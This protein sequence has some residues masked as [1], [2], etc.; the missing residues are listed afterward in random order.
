MSTL[1]RTE[2][3]LRP[4]EWHFG[5]RE[6]LIRTLLGSCVSITL[7]HPKYKLGGMCH[8]MLARRGKPHGN[9]L[10]GR[11]ADEAMLLLVQQVLQTGLALREFHVKLIGGAAVLADNEQELSTLDVASDNVEQARR[12]VR[13]LGLNLKAED[14]GGARPR[15]VLLDLDRGDVWVRQAPEP[16]F[17]AMNLKKGLLK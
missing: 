5:G 1:P 8:F 17:D 4:G 3:Y 15:L 7:W 6:F 10:S 9:A 14:L 16:D 12:L 11:Y 2:V 13:Q